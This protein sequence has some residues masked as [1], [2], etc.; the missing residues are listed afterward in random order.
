MSRFEGK[1]AVVTGAARGIGFAVA[2]SL[3]DEGADV[4]LLDRRDDD[5]RAAERRL[6]QGGDGRALRVD[7][8]RR[9]EVDAAMATVAERAGHI[10]VL[11]AN[12]GWA[13]YRPFL[14]IDEEHWRRVID[15]NLTG[16]FHV[17]QSGARVMAGGAR[18]GAIVLV[19]SITGQ[20]PTTDFAHY[21]AAK[22]GVIALGRVMA[23]ELGREGIRVNVVCPGYI[24][25]AAIEAMP[26]RDRVGDLVGRS[27]PLGR[28]GT[29]EEVAS[30]V[31]FLASDAASFIS[32]SIVTVSGGTETLDLRSEGRA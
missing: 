10:D 4:W 6:G 7:H 13:V 1:V 23:T 2:Q 11:V 26:D 29:P 3:V 24:A 25:T 28:F 31:L 5:L 18:P 30:T 16:T 32:G 19:S 8:T 22:A 9:D 21:A 27:V 14:E 17:A 15:A 20:V 12:A